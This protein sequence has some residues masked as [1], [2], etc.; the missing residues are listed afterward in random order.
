MT[1]AT[2]MG[3]TKTHNGGVFI[4]I[5]GTVGISMG[6]VLAIHIMRYRIGIG[7][8]LNNAERSTRTGKGMTHAGGTDQRIDPIGQSLPVHLTLNGNY[9]QKEEDYYAG[10]ILIDIHGGE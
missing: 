4:T 9:R 7:A 5:T 10:I 8:Q 6:L 3:M 2:Q 1:R